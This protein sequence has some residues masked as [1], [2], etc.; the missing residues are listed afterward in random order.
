MTGR[1]AP[2]TRVAHVVVAAMASACAGS[3]DIEAA[4][5]P[6]P[7][8]SGVP[9]SAPPEPV[10]PATWRS[11]LYPADWT[12]GFTLD[13]LALQDFS[14]AG[15]QAGQAP[16]PDLSDADWV[17]RRLP[18][19]EAGADPTGTA[20]SGP[21]FRATIDAVAAAG[22][23]VVWVPAGLYRIDAPIDVTQSGIII[24]GEGPSSQL[25]FPT[26]TGA[27]YRSQLTFR[28][29]LTAGE[30]VALVEDGAPFATTLR[31][32]DT[33]AFR[34]GDRV[35]VGQLISEAW[36]SAHGMDGYWGF[37]AGEWRPFYHRTVVQ[38][39]ADTDTLTLDVPLRYPLLVRDGAS[40]EP[41]TGWLQGCGLAD[42]AVSDAVGWEEAWAE[43]QAHAVGLF[44]VEDCW[45]R[46]LTS[47]AGPSGRGP[48]GEEADRHLRSGGII[49]ESSRRVTVAE[50]HLARPQHRGE[51]GNGYLFEL[52]QSNE[53][54]FR[55]NT[56]ELGRHNFIQNWDFGASG[57]VWLRNLSR[58]SEQFTS[59]TDTRG[60]PA[61]SETHHAL[62]TANLF[63][64]NQIEDAWKTV[65]RL[66][67]SSGAG[68]TATECVYWNNT[69]SGS[70]TSYQ[71]GRGYIIEPNAL[72]VQT[73]VIEAY[74]SLGTA[75]EDWV[76][77]AP[78]GAQL[79][80]PSL[81]EDQL[82]R[83]L[84]R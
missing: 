74:E 33:R 24:A 58:G 22:G 59:S 81:Y 49:V 14:Y 54:L 80:P 73:T 72:Q 71:F 36:V 75:P 69:G 56:A 8:D 61:A 17:G 15:F 65:N 68:H 78:E 57:N 37:S 67:Y 16:L 41:V 12:P 2:A 32:A 76:E 64:S 29:A 6:S 23:G 7:K 4:R 45:V 21:A 30:S 52:R 44:A 1:F 13:G 79:D 5:R 50:S 28:G 31:V 60:L 11:A 19:T 40:V 46:G 63:D 10:G 53:V 25:W 43:N 38:V 20:D 48:D 27:S 84:G 70:I 55:D 34:V 39:D 66:S 62:A 18:V 83:R 77:R 3:A 9:D 35:R 82:R 51:G 42:L 47:F 26:P